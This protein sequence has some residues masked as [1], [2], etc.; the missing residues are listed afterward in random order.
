MTYRGVVEYTQQKIMLLLVTILLC[1]VACI[2]AFFF[3][4]SWRIP[5][6]ILGVCI[7]YYASLLL[8]EKKS[9]AF[10]SEIEFKVSKGYFFGIIVVNKCY[11]MEQQYELKEFLEFIERRD[12]KTFG[13]PSIDE[14]TNTKITFIREETA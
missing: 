6:E 1:T 14:L 2:L 10:L 8:S 9:K 5:L 11:Q 13:I 4:L 3:S 7:L 12:I